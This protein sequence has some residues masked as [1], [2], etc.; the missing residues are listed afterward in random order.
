SC[1]ASLPSFRR[2]DGKKDCRD[3]RDEYYDGCHE[4]EKTETA[5]TVFGNMSVAVAIMFLGGVVVILLGLV[6]CI[7]CCCRRGRERRRYDSNTFASK[8]IGTVN[9]YRFVAHAYP[10]SMN[11]AEVDGNALY[12]VQGGVVQLNNKE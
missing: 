9:G 10:L 4:D 6:F 11:Y 8:K 1:V 7:C 2:C 5:G 3:G 12:D